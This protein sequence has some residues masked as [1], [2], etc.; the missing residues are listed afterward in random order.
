MGENQFGKLLRKKWKSGIN[1]LSENLIFVNS[2]FSNKV[3]ITKKNI[4]V[5]ICTLKRKKTEK[6]V[7]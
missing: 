3:I 1:V 4:F 2:V 5:R 6:S 7:N